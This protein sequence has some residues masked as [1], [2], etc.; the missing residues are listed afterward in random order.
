MARE[1]TFEAFPLLGGFSLQL[2][3]M[4]KE[5]ACAGDQTQGLPTVSVSSDAAGDVFSGNM[6]GWGFAV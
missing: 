2:A 6:L 5:G 1:G 4:G 3:Q